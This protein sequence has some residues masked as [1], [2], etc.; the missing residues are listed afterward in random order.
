MWL[1]S[2][3]DTLHVFCIL[4]LAVLLCW[5]KCMKNAA[6]SRVQNLLNFSTLASWWRTGAS[7]C[8][9]TPWTVTLDLHHIRDCVML[10]SH[11]L[12]S[13]TI[14]RCCPRFP[15]LALSAAWGKKL[16]VHLYNL[17]CGQIFED[18]SKSDQR[19]ATL[20]HE[21]N[22]KRILYLQKPRLGRERWKLEEQRM[23]VCIFQPEAT[24]LKKRWRKHGE[25]KRM[26]SNKDRT[27]AV[28]LVGSKRPG[29]TRQSTNSD[30]D[31]KWCN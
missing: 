28:F 2:A 1:H 15:G 3:K 22:C 21:I 24:S 29:R 12:Q 18:A 11:N 31:S 19:V 27:F 6:D 13:S 16:Q 25:Q 26:N 4:Y 14:R 30:S 7:V 5:T 23:A 17:F 8:G 10:M 20:A 9:E